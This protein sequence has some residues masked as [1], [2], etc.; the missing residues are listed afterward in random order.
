MESKSLVIGFCKCKKCGWTDN[1]Y[2]W[3]TFF[4]CPECGCREYIKG[5]DLL[6]EG[7]KERSNGVD[8]NSSNN[9]GASSYVSYE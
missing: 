5:V 7:E 3:H 8:N 4:R 2:N 6:A 1:K 9:S